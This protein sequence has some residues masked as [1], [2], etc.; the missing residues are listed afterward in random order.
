MPNLPIEHVRKGFN[1]F[2][3]LILTRDSEPDVPDDVRDLH[4]QPEAGH[5][6]ENAYECIRM[7]R[8][9]VDMGCFRRTRPDHDLYLGHGGSGGNGGVVIFVC[10]GACFQ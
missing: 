10:T 1:G 8:H 2:I 7:S 4:V 3:M 5:D 9:W 6:G